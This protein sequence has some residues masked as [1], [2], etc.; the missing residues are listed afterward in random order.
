M[1]RT[2]RSLPS[3]VNPFPPFVDIAVATIMIL[4]LL[5]TLHALQSMK[6]DVYEEIDRR[7]SAL[8]ARVADTFPTRWTRTIVDH[9]D[10]EEQLFRFSDEILFPTSKA[11]LDPGGVQLLQRFGATLKARQDDLAAIRVEGHTDERPIYY[12]FQS[13]W[14]LSTAR[15][16]AVVHILTDPKFGIGLNPR[17]VTA[18][19]YAEHH[20]AVPGHNETT[21]RLNRRIE[22]AIRYSPEAIARQLEE[23]A[24][25]REAADA[26]RQR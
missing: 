21:W 23:K 5:S 13:N 22:V 8:R 18:A 9:I 26:Q 7:Q 2:R 4:L 14:E 15:A 24:R 25:A 19:G 17:F 11:I 6:A 16:T 1:H 3:G 10:G 20:P 12:P